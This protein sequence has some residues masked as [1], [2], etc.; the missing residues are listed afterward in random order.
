MKKENKLFIVIAFLGIFTFC[1]QTQQTTNAQEPKTLE[2]LYINGTFCGWNWGSDGVI[3]MTP[4]N[5]GNNFSTITYFEAGT[6]FKFSP[7]KDWIGDFGALGEPTVPNDDNDHIYDIKWGSESN[8]TVAAAN[9]YNISVDLIVEKISVSKVTTIDYSKLKLNEISG[10]GNDDE[11]FYELINTGINPINLEGF[12]IYYNANGSS[13]EGYPPDNKRL[14]WTGNSTQVIEPYG[15]YTLM[16]RGAPGSFTTGLTHQRILIITLEDPYG[17]VLDQCIRARDTGEYAII[18]HSYSRIPDGTGPFY[19]TSTTTPD[20]TNGTSTE[21]L[22]L[23]PETPEKCLYLIG[24]FCNWSWKSN[25]LISMTASDDRNIFSTITYFDAGTKF[26]FSPVK[27]WDGDFGAQGEPTVP[28]NEIE[29]IYDIKYGG[30]SD[31]T[32][33]ATNYYRIK[34]DMIE[35]K[36]SVTKINPSNYTTIKLNEVSGAGGDPAKFYE[37]INT[38]NNPI[39]LEGFKIYYNAN[40]TSGENFPPKDERLTWTGNSTQIIEPNGFYTLLGRN[41]PGSFTTGLT[42]QRILIITLEDPFGN[43]L[44]QCIRARDTGEYAFTEHSFSRIPD[45]TGPF[46]FTSTTTPDATNGTSVEGLKLVP[47][48]PEN[49]NTVDLYNHEVFD[50]SALPTITLEVSVDE[51]NTLLT[52]YD[53]NPSNEEKLMANFTFSKN[54][55]ETKLT[56]IAFRI[57]GNTSRRRPEGNYG[58]MHNSTNPTWRNAHF[59]IDFR[60]FNADQRL[61]GLRKLI[62]KWHKDDPMFCR[63]VYSYDLFAKFGVWTAPRASYCKLYIKIGNEQPAYFGIYIM[64]EQVDE[65]FL[66]D[67]RGADHLNTDIGNL[68]KCLYTGGSNG[69][70]ADLTLDNALYKMGVEDIYLDENQS[71]RYSY[72][73]KTNK[74]NIGAAKPEFHTWITNLNTL[75]GNNFKTWISNYIDVD[76]FLKTY[77][78]NVTV[79]MWDD[80]WGNANNYYMY[81]ERYTKKAYFISFDYDNSLGTT[82]DAFD[83]GSEDVLRWG[84]SNTR[85]L[86][87]K[88]LAIPEY[89]DKYLMY[90][91]QLIDPSKDYFH[92]DKSIPRIEGWHDL[93]RNHLQSDCIISLEAAQAIEDKPAYWSNKDYKLFQRG[94]M[95]FFEVKTEAI[96]PYTTI[97]VE[98]QNAPALYP[99]PVTKGSLFIELPDGKNNELIQIFDISGKLL[100][101]RIIAERKTEINISNLQSG[102]YIVKIGDIYAKIIKQ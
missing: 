102:L 2:N 19:F 32:V 68:W 81:F 42:S 59:A 74:V 73:L 46:Y 98:K 54:D 16:G 63:E 83:A 40:S 30:N 90:L 51:W 101:T 28:D 14:T 15:F 13:G 61:F 38:G 48:T 96:P 93:I 36:I 72:D 79:G 69:G 77:A 37:L 29:N 41:T 6:E 20:A 12:K 21:G 62:L 18:D 65:A 94:S 31:I 58:E 39:N 52:N 100:L 64:I 33:S 97:R 27:D 57:R 17:N 75:T 4:F 9:Y 56:N 35:E 26:K 23:V 87:N 10:V 71:K 7:I 22:I 5:N 55:N 91:D 60:E 11:K 1:A 82:W 34:V 95:N 76:L 85:P 47:Q 49:E 24:S 25:E 70:A 44:D 53:M 89:K 78:V 88:I 99:N 66:N 3:T 80:Y 86:I 8:I 43:V 45:G 92:I 84:G 67:R 50:L